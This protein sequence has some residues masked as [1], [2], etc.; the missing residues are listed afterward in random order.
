[1]KRLNT[2]VG[3]AD[4]LSVDRRTITKWLKEI[5]IAHRRALTPKELCLFE[6][7]VSGSL[8]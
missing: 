7:K 1:M 3:L 8:R 4:K 5:G 2:R 6:E